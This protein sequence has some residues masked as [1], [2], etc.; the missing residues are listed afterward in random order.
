METNYLIYGSERRNLKKELS[1]IKSYVKNFWYAHQFDK[2]M[3]QIYGEKDGQYLMSDKEAQKKYDD[4]VE[5]IK[6][7]ELELKK[8]K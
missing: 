4:A 1:S 3:C 2:D 5:K 6:N 8:T 7:I